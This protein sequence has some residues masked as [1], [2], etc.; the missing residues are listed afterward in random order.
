MPL[1]TPTEILG[2]WLSKRAKDTRV[3]IAIDS[4]RFL[5]DANILARPTFVD[6]SGR[7]WQLAVFRGDDLAFRLQFRD[8]SSNGRALLVLSRGAETTQ[9][10]D[11]SCVSDIL[12][13]DEA[14]EPLDLSI[15]ALFRRVAPKINFPVSELRRFKSELLARTDYVEE[16]A[17]KVIQKWGKPD[18]W[19]RGQVASMVLLAHYP[20]LNLSDIWPDQTT[21]TEF[22]AH[23]VRLLV[24]LTQL[25]GK[26]H[27]VEIVIRE[28]ARE[29][30]RDVLF[31][32]GAQPE[33]LAAYLVLREFAGQTKLQ[34]PSTQLA[35]LP[36]FSPDLPLSK[37]ERNAPEVIVALKRQPK[38]WAAVNQCAESFLTPRRAS[39]VLELLPSTANGIPDISL[40]LQQ[41]NPAILYEQL[42]SALRFIFSQ[43]QPQVLPWIAPLEGHSLLRAVEP[44]SE[45]TRQCRA[46]LNLLLRLHRIEKRLAE[47]VPAFKHGDVLLQWF[48]EKDQHLLELDLSHA[49]HDLEICSDGENGVQDK[50]LEYLYGS[51]DQSRPEVGSLK[52]RILG[53]LRQLDETLAEFVRQSSDQFGRGARSTRGLLRSKIDVDQ[54]K[55]G[56]LPGRVWVL[57]FDGMRFDTWE[58][59]VKPVLAEFFEIQDEPYFCVLPSFTSFARTGLFAGG[60]PTEWKGFKGSFS[61]NEQQLFAVNMGLNPQDAKAKLRFVVEADTTKARAKLNYADKEAPLLNVLIYP[62]SDDTCHDFGGDLASFNNKIRA[63]MVGNRSD[64]V[65]GILDDLLKRIGPE[66]TVV[67]S[68]DHGFVELLPGDSVQ[69][70]KAEAEK[71]GVTLESSVHWRYV[72]A[73][74]PA[75]MPEA[76]AVPVASN[77]IWMAQGRR[78]FS[79]EG[80]KDTPRYS[81]G[82]LSMAEVVVPGVVLHRVTNKEARVELIDTPTVLVADEDSVF[83][84][85]V[86]VRN[87]GNCK[88]DF[89]VRV[90]TNLGEE[91]L[92]WHTRLAPATTEKKTASGVAKYKETSDREPDPNNTVAAITVRL[93]HTDL[94]GV[95]RDAMDGLITIPVKV[96]PKPVKLETDALKS[97]DDI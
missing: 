82:G 45:R 75:Q 65:R 83:E 53:R 49:H 68:S 57:L 10:I 55:A 88:V 26:R 93:R 7:E 2:E 78:W 1:K 47:I 97:F 19:G 30:V 17:E 33:E 39:R 6:I 59:V 31:W 38:M 58:S 27:I 12:A 36:L 13:K 73:F 37:M 52:W 72:E 92:A 16:A 60:L 67:L 85:P 20:E 62:V 44:F 40:L 80:T 90:L 11:V 28:A 23:V 95:W 50:G 69:V 34:N 41:D 42:A 24:G 76:V 3:A 87:T 15:T 5:M 8:A 56:T 18:S 46:A 54:I 25:R 48:T 29:Q 21:A 35:G 22:L 86:A 94:L 66:D 71:A 70:S 51:P 84:L 79:R 4:D 77:V 61:D 63:D 96:R 89:E 74:A 81:H 64:G 14:G 9:P 91:L 32:A 43:A